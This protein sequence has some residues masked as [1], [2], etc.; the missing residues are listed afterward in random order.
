MEKYISFSLGIL[1]FID[2]Y[3]FLPSSLDNLVAS[4][5]PDDFE[6]MKQFE[7]DDERRSL[8]LRKGVYPY[9][10]MNSFERFNETSLPPKEAFYSTLT[11][12][13]ISEEDY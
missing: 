7:P 3:Q 9:E 1:R 6:I 12:S 4:N 5:K 11:D 8:V 10:D 2:S 13:H